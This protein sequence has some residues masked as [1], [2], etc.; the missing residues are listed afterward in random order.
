MSIKTG[1]EWDK[2]IAMQNRLKEDS[3]TLLSLDELILISLYAQ[4]D[5]PIYGKTVF[6][7]EIFVIY[8]EIFKDLTNFLIQDGEYY[9]HKYGPYSEKVLETVDDMMWSGNVHIHGRRA[10]Q[11][12]V[13]SLSEEGKER[14]KLLYEELPQEIQTK[15]TETR[16]ELDQLGHNG[17]INHVYHNYEEYTSESNIKDEHK[18]INWGEQRL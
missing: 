13:Y 6:V 11:S 17:I 14:A 8:E 3:R 16:K 4:Q 7:K 12:K 2:L 10:D 9:A 15:L 1:S 18:K 5:N